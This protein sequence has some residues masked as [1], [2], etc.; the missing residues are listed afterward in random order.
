VTSNYWCFNFQFAPDPVQFV[1]I[2]V[3]GR[4]SLCA[5]TWLKRSPTNKVRYL[6]LCMPTAIPV[7]VTVLIKG[8]SVV[9]RK[10]KADKIQWTFVYVCDSITNV[11]FSVFTLGFRNLCSTALRL[12]NIFKHRLWLLIINHESG[13][14]LK[15]A[16]FRIINEY[17]HITQTSTFHTLSAFLIVSR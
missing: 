3:W 16:V 5:S 15:Y 17:L 12:R 4:G 1:L 9:S 14:D 7:H 11:A 10:L 8:A 2:C 13:C 6:S